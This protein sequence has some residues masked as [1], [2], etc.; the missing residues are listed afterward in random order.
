MAVTWKKLAYSDHTHAGGG[1]TWSIITGNTDAVTGN[2]YLIN[3]SAGNVTLTLPATPS[4]G[5]TVSACD[6]YNKATTNVITIARNGNKIEGAAEDLVIDLNGAGFEL[7][8]VDSTRGWD[9]VSE[10]GL[11]V[12]TVENKYRGVVFDGGGLPIVAGKKAF[13]RVANSGTII[14]AYAMAD[15]SGSIEIAV[16]KDTFANFPPTIADIISASA[17]ITL[18]SAQTVEDLTLTGWTKTV[19]A[20]DVICL[21]VNALA[22]SITWVSAGLIIQ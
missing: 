2:G 15:V 16:W 19:T 10:I 11:P 8:Y 7:V 3:A 9:I 6:V 14:G 4:A 1:I 18:S 12:T 20:G 21:N 13:F 5:D 22:T 17:P